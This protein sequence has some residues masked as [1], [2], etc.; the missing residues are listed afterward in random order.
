MNLAL[1]FCETEFVSY[2]STQT[3]GSLTNFI[4]LLASMMGSLVAVYR[5]ILGVM[6]KLFDMQPERLNSQAVGFIAEPTS[7]DVSKP[8]TR[9]ARRV[10][11]CGDV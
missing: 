8:K 6:E 7:D 10:W 4:V 1:F 5:T 3:N 2:H 9:S 11:Y